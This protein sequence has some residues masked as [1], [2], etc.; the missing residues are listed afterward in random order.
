MS[1]FKDKVNELVGKMEQGEDGTWSLP[2]DVAKDLDEPTLF[3]VTA[4]RRYRDTQSGYTKT[5][6]E[7]KRNQGVLEALEAH[8]L[9]NSE[10]PLTTEQ[11]KELSELKDKDPEAWRAKLNEYEQAGKSTLKEQLND[12]ASKA[13]NKTELEIRKEQMEAWSE[14]TGIELND[15][16]IQNDVP[17]RFLKKLESGEHSFPEFLEAVGEFLTA[18]KAI[19]KPEESGSKTNLDDLPGGRE[20]DPKAQAADTSESYK[21]TVF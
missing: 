4:E 8:I 13:G 11:R 19:K 17:P 2:E 5:R 20:P 7:L 10:I 14:E 15:D 21:D 6:Q 12:I 16:I 1:E 18:G 9:E 3:A